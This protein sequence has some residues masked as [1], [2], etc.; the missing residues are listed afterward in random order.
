MNESS[1][2]VVESL[3]LFVERLSVLHD[4]NR[5]RESLSLPSTTLIPTV[6]SGV[7]LAL[8]KFQNSFSILSLH[9]KIR[10]KSFDHLTCLSIADLITEE[11]PTS[12]TIRFLLVVGSTKRFCDKIDG[13]FINHSHLYPFMVL[14]ID[15]IFY[16]SGFVGRLLDAHISF[17]V[18]DAS[19][20]SQINF[21]HYITYTYIC[22]T[23]INRQMEVNYA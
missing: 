7:V 17:S 15:H 23:N 5:H 11:R 8:P 16:D 10:K 3:T 21:S 13:S 12:L 20:V 9:T 4:V 22:G 2:T 18:N 14:G 1:R 6:S 19:N